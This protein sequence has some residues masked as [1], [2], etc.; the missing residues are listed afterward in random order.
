VSLQRAA[1]AGAGPPALL[2][3]PPSRL[4]GRGVPGAPRRP[5]QGAVPVGVMPLV[6]SWWPAPRAVPPVTCPASYAGDVCPRARGARV[7]G[8]AS[9]ITLA[10]ACM[11]HGGVE[12]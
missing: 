1:Q 9:L 7:G 4:R 12:G 11:P 2:P 10:R 3:V 5:P 6:G 8:G